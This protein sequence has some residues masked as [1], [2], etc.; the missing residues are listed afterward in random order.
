MEEDSAGQPNA[1]RRARPTTTRFDPEALATM[2]GPL[3]QRRRPGFAWDGSSYAALGRTYA[4]NVASLALHLPALEALVTVAPTGFPS[5]PCLADTLSH[6]HRRHNIFEDEMSPNKCRRVA[7]NAADAWR[8][9]M[10]HLYEIRKKGATPDSLQR[11]FCMMEL[12][13]QP[14]QSEQRDEVD[15]KNDDELVVVLQKK[16]DGDTAAGPMQ[17]LTAT[18]VAGM[19]PMLQDDD[20]DNDATA[21]DEA[22]AKVSVAVLQDDDSD[23]AQADEVAVLQDG[24]DDDVDDDDDD[25]VEEVPFSRKC[26]CPECAQAS[27]TNQ[28]F[29]VDMRYRDSCLSMVMY[30]CVD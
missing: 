21:R 24:D 23:E 7:G 18:D 25:S 29:H 6:I 8:I 11:V 1:R 27:T 4:P 3:A 14:A 13:A 30:V 12:P 22:K 10:R 28:M 15:E 9:M 20:D 26:C 19:F 16:P 17:R 2:W 5:Q